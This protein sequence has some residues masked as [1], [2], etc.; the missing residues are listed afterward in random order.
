VDFK[1]VQEVGTGLAGTEAAN[2]SMA[3]QVGIARAHLQ[4]GRRAEAS[5]AAASVPATFVYNILHI[6]NATQRSLGNQTQS[7]SESRIS[8]VVSPEFRAMADAGDPRIT[9]VNAGRLSQDGELQFY[10]QTKFGWGSPERY[11][12]G[13]EARYIKVEAD[14]DPAAMLAFINERR[15]VGKQTAMAA[16][17]D[18]NALMSELMLQKS[19]DFW[20][21]GKGMADFR[22]NPNNFPFI[23]QPGPNYYKPALGPVRDQTCW[24]VPQTEINNNPNW[25][26]A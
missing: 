17:T 1:K 5:A 2:L 25:N 13:L 14:Q 21:E 15:A 9:Y 23:L 24:P 7:W 10:R 8:L 20:L 3:A 12:S 4:A 22:R 19:K 11:A 18:L 6:D 26:K 16:T